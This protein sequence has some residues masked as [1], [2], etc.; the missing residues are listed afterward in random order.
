MINIE[1]EVLECKSGV[2]KTGR[3]YNIALIRA[4]GVVGKL[5]SDVPLT[6]SSGPQ[7]LQIELSSNNE[8]FLSPKVKG[9]E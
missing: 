6:V 9:V 3:A 1:A 7:T 8:L 2:S 4:N 5:F